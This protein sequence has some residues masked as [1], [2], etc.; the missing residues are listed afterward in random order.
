MKNRRYT[1]VSVILGVWLLSI[2]G[3]VNAAGTG[4]IGV[5]I[6]SAD[7]EILNESST[8]VKIFGGYHYTDNLAMELAI[9]NLGDYG[10]VDEVN[11]G[12]FYFGVV[13]SISL[14]Q[15][16]A[17]FGKIGLFAWSVDFFD[18]QVDSGTDISWGFGVE[19]YI[20]DTV[21]LR[22]EYEEFLDV[23]GGDITLLS[24]GISVIF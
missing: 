18:V 4:Y 24:G 9:V 19:T 17:F 11:Q 10:V 7:D 22:A 23:S 20:S 16:T 6:G 3:I 13:P 12:G 2:A 14:N 1:V 8:G 21:L 15:N 5:S